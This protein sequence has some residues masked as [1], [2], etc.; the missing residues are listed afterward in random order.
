MFRRVSLAAAVVLFACSNAVHAQ[1]QTVGAPPEAS[2]MKLVG[3]HDL[4]A[5]SAYQPTIHRQGDRWIAYIGH[6]GGTEDVPAPVNPMTGKAEPNGTS[7][8]DVTDPARPKYLRHLPGQEGKYRIRR[9]ADGAGL[10]RQG[11]AEGRSQCGLH[12]QDLRQRGA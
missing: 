3:H 12:A 10:R 4:Q 5:R 1:M 8:V 11:L 7:I 2:N 9:R 6:H